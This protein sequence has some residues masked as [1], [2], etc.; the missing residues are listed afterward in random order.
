[1]N[2]CIVGAS[3]SFPT[4][5]FPKY[6]RENDNVKSYGNFSVGGSSSL[7]GIRAI[8]KIP[9]NKYDFALLDFTV[10]E[11]V[12]YRKGSLNRNHLKSTLDSLVIAL[13]EKFITPVFL[14]FPTT[15]DSTS[16]ITNFYREYCIDRGLLFFDIYRII[17]RWKQVT[18]IEDDFFFENANHIS[19]EFSKVSAQLLIESLDLIDNTSSTYHDRLDISTHKVSLYKITE[20]VAHDAPVVINQICNSVIEEDLI[21]WDVSSEIELTVNKNDCIIG[22]S[23]D[24]A[25]S[26]CYLSISGDNECLID[27]G[28]AVYKGNRENVFFI[29]PVPESVRSTTGK[30]KLSSSCNTNSNISPIYSQWKFEYD[31][32]PPL[33]GDISLGDIYCVSTDKCIHTSISRYLNND[34]AAQAINHL[35]TI[36]KDGSYE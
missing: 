25:K 1:M 6:I 36:N 12:F 29:L 22:Y 24:A 14:I 5:A 28:T 16:V 15:T 20:C 27:L 9:S 21:S 3:N 26:S 13:N 33:S 17:D 23:F 30:F 32:F 19:P 34:L 35:S 8:E 10:N 31:S 7:L 4:M 2:I 18:E 11:N